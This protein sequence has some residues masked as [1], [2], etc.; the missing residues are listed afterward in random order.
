MISSEDLQLMISVAASSSKA[1][2]I[3]LPYKKVWKTQI[4][5]CYDLLYPYINVDYPTRFEMEQYILRMFNQH[6]STKYN[7]N[8]N[9]IVD[10]IGAYPE[11][12]VYDKQKVKLG[13]KV[14]TI[15]YGLK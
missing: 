11:V 15:G 1:N 5:G 10:Q 8:G 6:N 2:P 14:N 13:S 4:E 12:M 3:T 9:P 7:V